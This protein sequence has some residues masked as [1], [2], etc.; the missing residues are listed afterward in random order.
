M[1]DDLLINLKLSVSLYEIKDAGAYES[2]YCKFLIDLSEWKRTS[3]IT[4]FLENKVKGLAT[5]QIIIREKFVVGDLPPYFQRTQIVLYGRNKQL[6]SCLGLVEIPRESLPAVSG[7]EDWYV[8]RDFDTDIQIAGEVKLQVEAYK[9]PQG[10]QISLLFL[11]GRKLNFTVSNS[12]L[13]A[14][15]TL[16]EKGFSVDLG[17][18]EITKGPALLFKSKETSFCLTDVK[19]LESQQIMVCLHNVSPGALTCEDSLVG[20]LV[21][22]LKYIRVGSKVT[23]WYP[24]NRYYPLTLGDPVGTKVRMKL[25]YSNLPVLPTPAYEPIWEVVKDTPTF[26]TEALN[27]ES[28]NKEDTSKI[29]LK[30]FLSKNCLRM[31]LKKLSDYEVF[32]TCEQGDSLF[33]SN[34]ITTKT[35]EAFIKRVGHQYLRKTVGPSIEALLKEKKSCEI[36][37]SFIKKGSSLGKNLKTLKRHVCGVVET[38]LASVSECPIEIRGAMYD[39]RKSAMER[40]GP[41]VRYT[42]VAAFLIL[43]FFSPAIMGPHLFGLA[44]KIP[45]DNV[46]RALTLVA[47]CVKNVFFFVAFEEKE[48]YMLPMNLIISNYTDKAKFFFDRFCTDSQRECSPLANGAKRLALLHQHFVALLPDLKARALKCTDSKRCLQNLV[49]IVEDLQALLLSK[50]NAL[51]LLSKRERTSVAPPGPVVEKA[52]NQHPGEVFT[53]EHTMDEEACKLDRNEKSVVRLLVRTV[54]HHVTMLLTRYSDSDGGRTFGPVLQNLNDSVLGTYNAQHTHIEASSFLSVK[55]S[56][57]TAFVKSLKLLAEQCD[58]SGSTLEAEALMKEALEFV[59]WVKLFA[60]K[61]STFLEADFESREDFK[62]FKAQPGELAQ[63]PEPSKMHDMEALTQDF[64]SLLGFD[65]GLQ[66]L[67]VVCVFVEE[68]SPHSLKTCHRILKQARSIH[69]YCFS[70]GAHECSCTFNSLLDALAFVSATQHALLKVD[71]SWQMNQ[72]STE[73]AYA[74]ES[75][76]LQMGFGISGG[77]AECNLDSITGTWC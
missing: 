61:T 30:A 66:D 6:E 50:L 44:D 12:S 68:S 58:S 29:L 54:V 65:A 53:W 35:F 13:L 8:L 59:K 25:F 19:D 27:E 48:E 38:I 23:S 11:E 77:R 75:L 43:R 40:F 49:C 63:Q 9:T 14:Y 2:F 34:S 17:T 1:V 31:H 32:N 45:D 70:D 57:L 69:G 7:K 39:L 52:P 16:T 46:S 72:P 55:Y 26:L 64:D 36:N 5:S 37:P 73:E 71:V 24:L 74:T 62:D 41:T 67:I 42:A 4:N 22:P 15:I 33:R 76:I 18:V 56:E 60:S 28:R 21:I 47:K 10:P 51:K 3:V 20:K